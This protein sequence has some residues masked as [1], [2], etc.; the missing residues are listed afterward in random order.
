[1]PAGKVYVAITNHGFGH[2]TRATSVAATVKQLAPETDIILATT[3]P[4][5]LL[6]S[7]FDASFTLRANALDIGV[8]QADS[9]TMDKARP[10]QPSKRFKPSKRSWLSKKRHF[11]SRKRRFGV[12]R[13]SAPCRDRR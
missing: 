13:Y 10:C 3:A 1:M 7:Y 9:L 4:P 8:L 6:E 11:S 12:G 5:W 2:A